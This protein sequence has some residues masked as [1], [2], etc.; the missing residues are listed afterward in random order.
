MFS[1]RTCASPASFIILQ[2]KDGHVL[3]NDGDE[4]MIH[5]D[6]TGFISEDLAVKCP[7]NIYRGHCLNP[8]NVEVR[9]VDYW[10]LT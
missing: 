1:S 4:R 10:L 9:C 2:D 8:N 3:Y 7:K 5:T 6:G